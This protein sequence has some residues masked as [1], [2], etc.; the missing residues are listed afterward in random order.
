MDEDI[1]EVGNT[2]SWSGAW[3]TQPAQDAVVTNIAKCRFSGDKD[4]VSVDE[5]LWVDF[6]G[7]DYI[8]DLDNGSW[9]WAS[10]I[11]RK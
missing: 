11:R 5:V 4:G 9:A 6:V 10:Q 2:V 1:L 7:R 3:G 8:V